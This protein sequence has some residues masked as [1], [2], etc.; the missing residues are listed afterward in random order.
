[1]DLLLLQSLFLHAR[2]RRF[3]GVGGRGT[4]AAFAFAVEVHRRRLQLDQDRRGFQ[5]IGRMA[6]IFACQVSETELRFAAALPQEIGIYLGGLRF[7]LAHEF[8]ER[9]R[10]EAQQHARCLDLVPLAV[11]RLHLQ[12]RVALC[13]H[14]AD[15]ER[16]GLFVQHVHGF[17][18]EGVGFVE[19]RRHP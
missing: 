15:L 19:R 11:R 10:L 1:M 12:R 5:R 3:E 7:G 16:A 9:R 8:G 6:A 13:E 2:K 18:A 4:K 14:G 17:K